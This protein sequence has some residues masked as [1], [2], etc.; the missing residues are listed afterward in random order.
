MGCLVW[1]LMGVLGGGVGGGGRVCWDGSCGMMLG[2]WGWGDGEWEGGGD[3][4]RRLR[5]MGLRGRK[6]CCNELCEWCV[7]VSVEVYGSMDCMTM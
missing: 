7:W 5:G 4:A 6:R 2:W 1:M 3:D